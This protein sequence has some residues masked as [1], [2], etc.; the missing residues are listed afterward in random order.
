[1]KKEKFQELLNFCTVVNYEWDENNCII[2][3]LE[4]CYEEIYNKDIVDAYTELRNFLNRECNKH[5]FNE[6]V[7]CFQFNDFTVEFVPNYED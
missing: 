5:F 1:M 4:D 3:D 2:D 7:E 6:Y